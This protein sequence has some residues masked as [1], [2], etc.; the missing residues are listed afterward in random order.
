MTKTI[1][2]A[3][4]LQ[5]IDEQTTTTTTTTTTQWSLTQNYESETWLDC[6]SQ[7]EHKV[8]LWG[9]LVIFFQER[10]IW[11][12]QETLTVCSL[13]SFLQRVCLKH[14]TLYHFIADLN[15]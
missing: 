14:V 13:G 7:E 2:L 8:K 3:I 11:D 6:I 10:N 15:K 5:L 12:D 4:L 9:F 1:E